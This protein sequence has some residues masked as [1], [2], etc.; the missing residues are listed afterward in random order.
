MYVINK[1][2][3]NAHGFSKCSSLLGTISNSMFNSTVSVRESHVISSLGLPG[4]IGVPG[5][6]GLDGARGPKGQPG[7]DGQQGEPGL[8][9]LD[10]IPGTRGRRGLF[11]FCVFV[12][13]WVGRGN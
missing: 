10:G 9:G 2:A 13:V 5:L 1:K 7:A 4:A 11:T 6:P 3:I 8:P 12:E